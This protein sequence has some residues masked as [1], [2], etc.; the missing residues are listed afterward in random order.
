[1][2]E[3]FYTSEKNIQILISLLKKYNIRKI[4][5]SPGATNVTFVSSVQR[6]AFFEIYSCVDERSAGYMACGL[7]QES[8]QPV[9]LSCTGATASRNYLPALTEAY[10]RKL[11]VIACTSSQDFHNVGHLIAQV[12]NR[13][14]PPK[15]VALLSVNVQSVR[16]ESDL[17]DC[18]IK[19]N[20]AL[21]E[22][23][24]RGG[25]PVHIN[26]E[27]TYSKDYSAKLLP[28]SREVR[29]ITPYSKSFPKI[30]SGRIAVFV[31]SHGK[32]T[33]R[34]REATE[35]FC[36]KFQ[37]SVFCDHTSNYNGLRS[38][39]Y[40]LKSSQEI[41]RNEFPFDLVI[42]LG[43]VS[44]DYYTQRLMKNTKQ[45]WRVSEDGEYRD[46]FKRLS[47][48][49]E[50][51]QEEFFDYYNKN[52]DFSSLETKDF[53]EDCLE[54]NKRLYSLIPELP[55]SNVY[56]A[57]QMAGLLPEN[58]VIH[59]GILNTLRSWNFFELPDSVSAFCNVG[60]FGIDG[61]LSSLVGASLCEKEKLY[62]GIL[63]DLALFY[64]LNVLANRHI[65]NNLRIL[66]VNNGLG[67]E[68]KNYNH[69]GA[70]F[71]GA[72]DL[73]IAAKGHN[74]KQSSELMKHFALDLG[75]E[76]MSAS[77]KDEFHKVYKRFLTP[78]LTEKPLFFEVFTHSDSENEALYLMR[79]IE[80]ETKMEAVQSK[81]KQ[82]LKSVVGN[83]V[84][85][86][87]K[88]TLGK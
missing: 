25:G 11:P 58:S 67:Q 2:E 35:E 52:T 80:K 70:R 55:F 40:T 81:V 68:F 33:Q 18:E 62:F 65:G 43:E 82:T 30:P 9:L 59:F 27:T 47:F 13:E 38:L 71:G 1:M 77:D 22:L 78:E 57:Q 15:D 14:N 16:T 20:K 44:G 45:V 86:N 6:D 23:T 7:A 48:V 69:P 64:D 60:A 83:S 42:H 87:L 63:G 72:T 56:L 51:T 84:L 17:W 37:A 36:K 41:R 66:L 29:R 31:G 88:D 49:F 26:L 74:G 19:I 12:I 8:S 79:T 76:Y 85:K 39:N 4:I 21:S 3:F 61:C 24:H 5:A 50:M 32:W 54:E 73:F 46:T 28:D 34:Q 75:F 53:Y 10:Y